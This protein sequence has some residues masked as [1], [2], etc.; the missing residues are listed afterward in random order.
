MQGLVS[1]IY[2][3]GR[4]KGVRKDEPNLVCGPSR[5]ARLGSDVARAL[6]PTRAAGYHLFG[7]GLR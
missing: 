3:T 6:T 5:G 1:V 4:G 7:S 2:L